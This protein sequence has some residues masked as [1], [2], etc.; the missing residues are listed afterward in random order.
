MSAAD[1]GHLAVAVVLTYV[2]GFER[3]LRGAPAGDRVFALIGIGSG[4]IGIIAARGAGTVLAGAITGIGFIGGALVY[5]QESNKQ[6]SV[7]G[8]T[9][10]AAIFA[11]AA[12]GASAGE[13]RLLVAISATAFALFVLEIRHVS[14]LSVLDGQHWSHLF[15]NDE[16]PP[17]P[18]PGTDPGPGLR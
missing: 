7:V 3:N 17:P 5:R 14:W 4:L 13:G 9:T 15:A 12:I 1:V 2:L 16:P 8:L 6:H 18:D 11:A 10:A